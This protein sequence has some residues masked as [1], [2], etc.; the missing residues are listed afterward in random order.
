MKVMVTALAIIWLV[1]CAQ[2]P[3]HQLSPA[4]QSRLTLGIEYMKRNQLQRARLQ[5]DQAYQ[6]APR[7]EAVI[8]ALG[9]WYLRKENVKSALLLYQQALTWQP[10]S[11]VLYSNYAIALCLAGEVDKALAMFEMAAA[12]NQY[13]ADNRARCAGRAIR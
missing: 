1:G 3:N 7:S 13:V 9:Q 8:I 12:S 4:G 2:T 11:G 10:I 5:L 6:D